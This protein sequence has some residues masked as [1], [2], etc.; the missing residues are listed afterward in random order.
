MSICS[1]LFTSLT[2]SMAVNADEEAKDKVEKIVITG[3]RIKR[4][5]QAEKS[6][7]ISSF[8]QSDLNDIGA[9][10]VRDLIEVLPINAGSQNNSDNLSQNFTVGTSNVNLRGLGVS[11]TLVLLNGKRQVT[12]AVLTDQGA[13]FVDTASLVPAL[14]V[15]RVEILKDGASAIYGSDAVAGVVNFITRDDL[16]GAEF[17]YEYRKRISEGSQDETKIDFAIGGFLGESGHIMLAVSYLDRSSLLLGEVDWLKPANS[18]FGNPGSYVIPSLADANNPSG[19]TIADPNCAD[20]GGAVSKGSNGNTFCLFDFGPQVTAVPEENRLQGYARANWDWSDTVTAWAEFGF[21]QNKISREVSPSFPVLNAPGILA[22]HPDNPFGEDVSFR[23]RPYG[24]GKP[25]ETNYYDHTTSR[26]AFGAE[27]EFSEDIFWDVS[28]V[29][30]QNDALLNPR[31]VITNNFQAALNGFGG[32]NC[33]S[34]NSKDAG[35]G[36]C[37]YFNPFDPKDPDNEALRSYIIGDYLADAESKMHVFEAIISGGLLE[38]ANGY[39]E[40]ALGFQYREESL[41]Y[42]YDSLTQ[43][44]SFAFLIGNQNLSGDRNVTSVFA[45]VLLPV[46]DTVEASVAVRYEDYGD[47]GGD[48]TDPKLSILW[49]PTDE[50]SFRT[51]ISTSF[52]A[53]SVHQVQG[54]Q[55]N[56]ANIT[57]PNDDSTTFGGNRTIGDPDLVPETSTAFNFGSSFNVSNWNFDLDYWR[58]SFEDVLTRESHQAIVNAY[59]N[60]PERVVRTSAGTITIVNTKFINAEAIDTSGIDI[61]ALATYETEYGDF[62]PSISATYLL[63]Y[64]LTD[65]SGNT[66]DGVGQL[67][68]NTVGNPS[69]ELRGN[70]GLNWS[71]GNHSANIFLR[72]VGSYENDSN[73]DSIDSFNTIDLQYNFAFGDMLK[74]NSETTITF[75]VVNATDENPPFVAISGSYD[76]RTGDP[77][78]R[79]VYLKFGAKF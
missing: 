29:T 1:A 8:D 53:P 31:D 32:A 58:F 46:A 12:S 70:A 60:D 50:L 66:V 18:S 19:L 78:G 2:A 47:L 56:F 22:N 35:Q 71:S 68:R 43:Q 65:I 76:P 21:A 45:E 5:I 16:D 54:A 72:H 42:V 13:S 79:R 64:D 20:N 69:P 63:S 28:F 14:A 24:V 27:G 49:Y 41:S 73:E 74:D 55:T 25:N 67:N 77:R 40:F 11:S 10:D 7:P 37:L 4:S 38:M 62:S 59:P 52:R 9:N 33:K 6:T 26:F 48:T 57:D 51:S 44:D 36:E 23:G 75:G 30:S 15:K 39:V 17:Q 34:I 3:S 61:S